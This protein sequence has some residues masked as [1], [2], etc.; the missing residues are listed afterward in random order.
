MSTKSS[1]STT[2]STTPN[3]S[4]DILLD[5]ISRWILLTIA[6]TA[7]IAGIWR[8][9]SSV[10]VERLDTTTLTYF[11]VAAA[12]LLLREVKTLTFGDYKVEF[13]RT[14]QAAEEA[15][16]TATDARNTAENAQAMAI[17]V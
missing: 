12:L 7:A 16:R 17:G 6:A 3:A 2:L 11:T 9:L 13:E 8:V 15:K 14:R 4:N 5:R 1:T 10:A